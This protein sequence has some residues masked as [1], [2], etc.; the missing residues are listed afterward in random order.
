[1][2]IAV[3]LDSFVSYWTKRYYMLAPMCVRVPFAIRYIVDEWQPYLF[4]SPNILVAFWL[5]WKAK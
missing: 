2:D 1:M 3:Y 5:P 4:N